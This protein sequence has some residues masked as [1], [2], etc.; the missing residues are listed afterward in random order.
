[1]E[2]LLFLQNKTVGFVAKVKLHPSDF[3]VA[4]INEDDIICCGENLEE[5]SSK[6][7][8]KPT[9]SSQTAESII[10]GGVRK[11]LDSHDTCPDKKRKLT[12]SPHENFSKPLD[13]K[14]DVEWCKSTLS[15]M[16]LP[17]TLKC[18]DLIVSNPL[19][20]HQA[21]RLCT[22]GRFPNKNHRT[23]L[24]KCVQF[25]YPQLATVTEKNNEIFL[26]PCLKFQS[27]EPFM[28]RI[29]A[30]AFMRF[31]NIFSKDNNNSAFEIEGNFDKDTRRKIHHEIDQHFGKFLMAKTKSNGAII[32]VKRRPKKQGGNTCQT[33]C[34]YTF[35]K[36]N[37]ESLDA[38]HQLAKHFDLRPHQFGFAGIKDKRAETWQKMTVQGIRKE[39]L[40]ALS[41]TLPDHLKISG[42]IVT[43]RPLR[44]G[45]LSGNRFII[46]STASIVSLK[47][48]VKQSLDLTKEQGF[49]N[50][51]GAQRFGQKLN[52]ELQGESRDSF[53]QSEVFEA[54][55]VGLAILRH[56][57]KMAIHTLLRPTQKRHNIVS[58]DETMSDVT[59]T[60]CAKR[61]F[62]DTGDIEGALK[63]LSRHRVRE[64]SILRALRHFG[65]NLQE[66]DVSTTECKK[67]PA[68]NSASAAQ[69]TASDYSQ[70]AYVKALLSLPHN[71]LVFYAHAYCS[72]LWNKAVTERLRH[73]CYDVAEGDLVVQ[74]GEELKLDQIHVV[75]SDDITSRRFQLSDVVLPLPGNRIRFP[76]NMKTFYIKNLQ[77]DRILGDGCEDV[78]GS[79]RIN[80]LKINL[81]G[82][83]RRII[84]FPRNLSYKFVN[85]L[86]P[87]KTFLVDG[88]SGGT[89]SKT[90]QRR[91]VFPRFTRAP[92]LRHGAGLEFESRPRWIFDFKVKIRFKLVVLR[93]HVFEGNFKRWNFE[94]KIM[95]FDKVLKTILPTSS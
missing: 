67:A 6:N 34:Q 8:A 76:P 89:G 44:T 20:M 46:R 17:E 32:E 4:E 37:T 10:D 42:I 80:S 77:E 79:F 72:F 82:A 87:F 65:A 55:S 83:Y 47:H 1:M 26:E 68:K 54:S 53:S 39:R 5:I 64:V 9:I 25:L 81:P 22:L 3:K 63:R 69:D 75:T 73:Y 15:G 62:Q 60:N 31:V 57:M 14:S 85:N 58:D 49:I 38:V 93:D 84:E 86:Q 2:N 30:V 88:G 66:I 21:D 11:T 71:A 52:E 90:A 12:D 61:Y 91:R 48:S 33:Y 50:Y 28:G 36:H 74:R 40:E 35:Y 27:F 19:E 23:L 41:L 24:H 56:D 95:A 92:C 78:S 45:Q 70:R 7:L 51:F 16:L 18:L 59:T 94:I 13:F 43:S 29:A